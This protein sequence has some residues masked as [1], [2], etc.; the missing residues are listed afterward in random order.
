MTLHLNHPE[1]LSG[2]ELE[3]RIVAHQRLQSIRLLPSDLF[4]RL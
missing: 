4:E 3:N 2:S 1:L